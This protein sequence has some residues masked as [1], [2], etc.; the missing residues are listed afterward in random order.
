MT[1]EEKVKKIHKVK[2]F[3]KHVFNSKK[4]VLV[5]IVEIMLFVLALMAL[6]WQPELG[7]P[8]A[9]FMVSV[10]FAMG[11]ILLTYIGKQSLLDAWT[12]GIALGGKAPGI[13]KTI[14]DKLGIGDE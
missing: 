11:F 2:Q 12:R 4:S 7:W 14:S 10:V 1:E 9:A 5:F 13:M 3:E 6:R 8:L